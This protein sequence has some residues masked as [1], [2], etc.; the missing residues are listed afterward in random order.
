MTYYTMLW[1]RRQLRRRRKTFPCYSTYQLFTVRGGGREEK[2]RLGVPD[3]KS[4]NGELEFER[5]SG[6]GMEKSRM[7]SGDPAYFGARAS[8]HPFGEHVMR[9][10]VFC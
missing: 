6:G 4:I 3:S 9:A 7:G 2:M 1:R 8:S 10:E 5:H